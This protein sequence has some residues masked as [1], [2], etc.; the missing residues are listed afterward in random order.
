ML[1]K[2][3]SARPMP[4]L[5]V[6]KRIGNVF[7]ECDMAEYGGTASMYFGAYAPLVV[8]AM[9]RVLRPGDVFID[10][11]SNIGYLS[12]VAADLVG[13]A[14]QVHA[15]E[16]VPAY[17]EK[18]RRFAA[19]NPEYPIEVNACAAGEVAG[20]CD[21]FVTRETGQSTIVPSYKPANE[22]VS[23]IRVPV[24][25]LDSYLAD[26]RIERVALIKIDAEGFEYPILRGLRMYLDCGNHRPAIICEIAPRA[27]QLLGRDIGELRQFMAGYGY[28]ARDIAD[29]TTPVDLAAVQHVEDVIFLAEG[30]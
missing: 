9:R 27:Y 28:A 22:I 6:R 16:P 30:R 5:P 17:A 26:H 12:A 15:F 18:L 24:V 11:G 25:R 3:N 4:A 20:V 7:F 14:G 29:G 8:D 10:V 13:P 23:V 2:L 19:L 21:I 1:G